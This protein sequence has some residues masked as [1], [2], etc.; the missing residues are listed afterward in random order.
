L[1]LAWLV[2]S[3]STQRSGPSS[4]S[5]AVVPYEASEAISQRRAEIA[6][7]ARQA[8][9]AVT[10]TADETEE[11]FKARVAEARA[12][13][14]DLQRQG[15]ETAAAFA[16]RVQQNF[17]AVQNSARETF[18]RVRQTAADRRDD[19]AAKGRQGQEAVGAAVQGAQDFAS[20][21]SGGIAETFSENPLLLAALGISAGALLGALL[22]KTDQEENLIGPAVGKAVGAAREATDEMLARGSRAAAAAVSA[23]SKAAQEQMSSPR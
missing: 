7:R 21:A 3:S 14:L 22:P 16:D 8:G 1:G 10:R 15:S 23:G 6:E 19:V 11:A 13:V 12:R 4:G 20:R 2:V 5:R 9:D 17:E 18:E